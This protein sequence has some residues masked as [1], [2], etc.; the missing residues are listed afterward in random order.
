MRLSQIEAAIAS[1]KCTPEL[2]AQFKTALRRAPKDLRPQ[3]CYT[4]AA[5]MPARCFPMAVEL[6]EYSLTLEGTWVDQMR[7]NN[8]LADLY[9]RHADYD[10]AKAHYRLALDAVPSERKPNYA[11]DTAARMLVCQ[12]HLD[13]FAYTDKL[14][15]LYEEAQKLDDFSRSFQKCLFYLSLTEI[16]LHK[17]DGDLPAARTACEQARAMLR[18]SYT[19]PLTALLKRKG[20][21]ESTGATNEARTFL[22]RSARKLRSIT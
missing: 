11:P 17:H 7:A 3:H 5:A 13:G 10:Q 9:E 15:R 12:L 16:I 1:G 2:L 21:A 19:G 6:L 20:Y 18:P 22:R 14:R 8:N 4:T